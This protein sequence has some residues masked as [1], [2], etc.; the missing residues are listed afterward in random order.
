MKK[1]EDISKKLYCQ[2]CT[3]V[4]FTRSRQ[5]S[6]IVSG[7]RDFGDCGEILAIL[8]FDARSRSSRPHINSLRATANVLAL[9]SLPQ[10]SKILRRSWLPLPPP[11][12][13][14]HEKADCRRDRGSPG[15]EITTIA[16]GGRQ[17]R[18]CSSQFF[19]PPP[20]RNALTT[21]TTTTIRRTHTN[22]HSLARRFGC[23]RCYH[24]HLRAHWVVSVRL[25]YFG[26][27]LCKTRSRPHRTEN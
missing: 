15:I 18:I 12:T 9:P 14:P 6:R 2:P 8:L 17:F 20:A 1:N 26:A 11:P 10:L 3:R 7:Q 24:R 23:H 13:A 16:D 5:V 22:T 25:V 19:Q 27:P 21:S 4:T